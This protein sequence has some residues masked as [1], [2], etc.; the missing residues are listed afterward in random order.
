MG[1]RNIYQ[2]IENRLHTIIDENGDERFKHYHTFNQQFKYLLG[3]QSENK[4]ISIPFPACFIEVTVDKIEEQSC[5]NQLWDCTLNLHIAHQLYNAQDGEFEQNWEVF[6][7][8]DKVHTSFQGFHPTE[9][10]VFIDQGLKQDYDHGNL[11]H[12]INTYK[13]NYEYP[14]PT[15]EIQYTG[16][17]LQITGLTKTQITY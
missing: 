16:A 6:D 11:Y 13:F 15:T 17:T 1:L 7:L 12:F 8:V 3:S 14:Y 10:G 5:M 2:I 4:D 9:F